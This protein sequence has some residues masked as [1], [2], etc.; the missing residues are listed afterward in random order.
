MVSLPLFLLRMAKA[1]YWL[2]VVWAA[3]VVLAAL[4]PLL[5]GK[6]DPAAI[7]IFLAVGVFG[8]VAGGFVAWIIRKFAVVLWRWV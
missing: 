7:F 4:V 5:F 3:V 2:G 6:W 1:I 8:Y